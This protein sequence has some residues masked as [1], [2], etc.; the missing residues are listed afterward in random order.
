MVANI[1]TID[2]PP[3]PVP[4]QP[5]LS[6]PG[7]TFLRFKPPAYFDNRASAIKIDDFYRKSHKQGVDLVTGYNQVIRNPFQG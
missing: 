4:E 3:H 6:R 5:P 7:R 1:M 2:A